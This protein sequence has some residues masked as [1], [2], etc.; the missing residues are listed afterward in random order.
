MPAA[1]KVTQTTPTKQ[2]PTM[3]AAWINSVNDMLKRFNRS[4]S[5]S[6]AAG[7]FGGYSLES[8]SGLVKIKNLTGSDL[9]R[10]NYVQLGDYLLDDL[11]H[12]KHWFEGNLYDSGESGRVAILEKAVKSSDAGMVRARIL[13]KGTA[14]VDITDIGHRFAIPVDG[15][16]LFASA[17]SGSIEILQDVSDTGEQELSVLIGGGSELVA[18]V[19][20]TTAID[21]ASIDTGTGKLTP[22]SITVRVLAKDGDGDYNA[23]NSVSTEELDVTS[24]FKTSTP[25]PGTG[26]WRLGYIDRSKNELIQRECETFDEPEE[27]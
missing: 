23:L 22:A 25:A 18:T 13:G 15:E 1:N 4:A 19:K 14:R 10:G 3:S 17:E 26:K 27:S 5:Q 9:L 16:S 8:S 11:D 2:W 12:H 21:S 24:L 6:D 20:I 7:A